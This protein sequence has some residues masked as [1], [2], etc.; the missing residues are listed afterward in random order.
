M[1]ANSDAAPG[2]GALARLVST[3]RWR[4]AVAG[5]AIA[6]AGRRGGHEAGM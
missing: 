1:L 2:G 6:P 4:F 5:M 3:G